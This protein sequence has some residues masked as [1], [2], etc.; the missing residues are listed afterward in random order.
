MTA[1]EEADDQAD[2]QAGAQTAPM[3]AVPRRVLVVDDEPGVRLVL[4][5]A[6]ARWDYEVFLSEGGADALV[7][8]ADGP[9]VDIL[10]S[11]VTMPGMSGLELAGTARLKYPG[12]PILFVT[13]LIDVAYKP[14]RIS[15]IR[16]RVAALIDWTER[17]GQ[18]ATSADA[19]QPADGDPLGGVPEGFELL[20]PGLPEQHP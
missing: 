8:L 6:L 4:G 1:A 12:L 20:I 3:T 5:R 17:P 7:Q 9:P 11:D 13:A 10:V 18:G 15:E 14:V 16:E 19:M 2:D